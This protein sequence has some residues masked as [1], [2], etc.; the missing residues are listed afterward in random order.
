M[1]LLSFFILPLPPLTFG[2]SFCA[3]YVED[4]E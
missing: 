4:E 2:I 1:D 3:G